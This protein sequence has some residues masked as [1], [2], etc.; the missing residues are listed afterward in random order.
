MAYGYWRAGMVRREAAFHLFFREE[1]FGGDYAIAAGLEP[2]IDYLKSF[3][4]DDD[5]LHHLAEF[6]RYGQALILI[7]QVTAKNFVPCL[8]EFPESGHIRTSFPQTFGET[9]VGESF[10]SKS[11]HLTLLCS[12]AIF[13]KE[14][15]GRTWSCEA[16]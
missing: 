13:R 8:D 6:F 5:D 15:P 1:P 7:V 14:T 12:P 3:R 9:G 4:F 16:G 10:F 2:V 11:R